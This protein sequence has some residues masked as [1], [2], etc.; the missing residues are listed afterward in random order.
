MEYEIFAKINRAD[1]HNPCATIII[2]AADMPQDEYDSTPANIIPMWPTDEYAINDFMS[3]WRR[4]IKLVT[5]APYRD[6]L[7]RA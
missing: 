6:K 7:K 4:Q 5:S 2:R 1:E 3:G